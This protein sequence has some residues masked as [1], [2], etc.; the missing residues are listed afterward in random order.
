MAYSLNLY[1]VRHN[2]RFFFGHFKLILVFKED[3]IKTVI[4]LNFIKRLFCFDIV[5]FD[6][7]CLEDKDC[8]VFFILL[9][10]RILSIYFLVYEGVL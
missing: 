1:D 10:V 3:F 5:N 2:K 9:S 6:K 8:Y 4:E 7:N